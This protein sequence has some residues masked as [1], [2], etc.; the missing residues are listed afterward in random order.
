M[1]KQEFL[2]TL[3]GALV[4]RL[5]QQRIE[6][7]IRY[8]EDY[9]DIRLRSGDSPEALAERLGDPRLLAKT[10]VTAD[11][12]SGKHSLR[13]LLRGILDKLLDLWNHL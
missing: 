7:H 1:D 4:G 12:V 9:I 13:G 2:S 11:S 10:L 8:Y 3:R 5:P 6:E